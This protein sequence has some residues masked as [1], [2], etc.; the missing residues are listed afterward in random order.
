M[1]TLKGFIR[2]SYWR[3]TFFIPKT[4]KVFLTLLGAFSLL[5][6]IIGFIDKELKVSLQLY[7][8]YLFSF[9]II[10]TVFFRRPVI[11]VNERLSDTDIRVE[12]KI[13]NIFN[14]KGAYVIPTNTTF[15][16]A[17]KIIPPE[18]VQ[19]KFTKKFYNNIQAL[20]SDISGALSYYN[21]VGT[22]ASHVGGKTYH[23]PI[24]TVAKI[25][26]KNQSAYLFAFS[27]LNKDGV[28]ESNLED[29]KKALASLW[30]FISS[31]GGYERLAIPIVG[32]GHCRLDAQR[33]TIIREIIRSF[34]AASVKQ[35]FTDK[36]TVVII[37]RDY[38]G[39]NLD[40]HEIGEFLKHV[41][42]YTET[43]SPKDDSDKTTD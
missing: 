43:H 6:E 10:L 40:I 39:H 41:C 18:S 5:T 36:L 19:G 24:G 11:A 33:G 42:K 35:K 4:A 1:N 20:D 21:V 13:S 31:K 22:K 34:I 28:A 27:Q 9:S 15:D 2:F 38:Y 26:P 29:V 23:Y 12:V 30:D 14:L 32:T 3:K 16:T 17:D 8:T 25:S 7:W 37:S